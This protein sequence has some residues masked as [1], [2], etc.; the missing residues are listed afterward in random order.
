MID[1]Q[2]IQAAAATIQPHVSKTPFL[3]SNLFNRMTGAQVC[4][5]M[6]PMSVRAQ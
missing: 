4:R 1:Y 2:D 5:A 6:N 3:Y